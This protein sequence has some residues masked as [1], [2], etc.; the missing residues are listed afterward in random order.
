MLK[1]AIEMD[2]ESWIAKYV[3]SGL[4]H[5]LTAAEEQN[6]ASASIRSYMDAKA[7]LEK[8]DVLAMIQLEVNAAKQKIDLEVQRIDTERANITKL[9]DAALVEVSA[10]V[11]SHTKGL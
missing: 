1:T 11:D 3:Q 9:M 8:N 6:F 5:C 10:L 4:K 7:H 2:R